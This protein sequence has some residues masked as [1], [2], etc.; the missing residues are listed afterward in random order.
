MSY[1]NNEVLKSSSYCVGGLLGGACLGLGYLYYTKKL[2]L[3]DWKNKDNYLNEPVY[4][5]SLMGLV[6]A[7]GLKYNSFPKLLK[8]EKNKNLS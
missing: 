5:G 8:I 7:L 6:I 3:N 4:L 1:L 2:K